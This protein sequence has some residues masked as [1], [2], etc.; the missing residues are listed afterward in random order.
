MRIDLCLKLTTLE[1]VSVRASAKHKLPPV[2]VVRAE[3]STT[4][5]PGRGVALVGVQPFTSYGSVQPVLASAE[6]AQLLD[7]GGT[8][9]L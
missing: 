7:D 2:C 9:F 6:L 1:A 4:S 8:N 5:S 3:V